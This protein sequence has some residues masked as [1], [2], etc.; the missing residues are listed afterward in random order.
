MATSFDAQHIIFDWDN[1]LADTSSELRLGM[2]KTLQVLKERGEELH[3]PLPSNYWKRPIMDSLVQLDYSLFKTYERIYVDSLRKSALQKVDLFDGV[4]PLLS[5]LKG[6]D[7]NLYIISNKE[8]ELLYKQIELSGLKHFFDKVVG[9]CPKTGFCKPSPGV[10]TKTLE[11]D[12]HP[13]DVVFIGDSQI[14]LKTAKAYGC[15]FIYV[16]DANIGEHDNDHTTVKDING[17]LAYAKAH[18]SY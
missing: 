8:T 9:L 12:V 6:C 10:F 4:R 17:L 18:L 14:D 3:T 5:F 7:K 1:T 11:K 13:K 2:D 15:D 16:G